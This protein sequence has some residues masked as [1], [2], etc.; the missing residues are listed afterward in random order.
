MKSRE[1]NISGLLLPL[2][3]AAALLIAAAIALAASRSGRGHDMSAAVEALRTMEA[4]DPDQVT[5]IVRGRQKARMEAERDEMRAKLLNGEIDVWSLLQDYVILGDSRP[6]GFYYYG[7]LPGERVLCG[8][9][10]TV[11]L[12]REERLPDIVALNPARAYISYGI[13]DINIGYWDTPE[14]YIAE[15]SS[16][17]DALE[18][19]VPG[20]EIY[21]NSILPVQDWALYKG[22]K[23]PEAPIYSEALRQMCAEKGYTYI[24]NDQICAEHQELYDSDG[25]HFQQ[26]FYDYWAT[27]FVLA[28]YY[29]DEEA[30]P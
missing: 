28:T 16:V 7:I 14:E 8:A 19:A 13:N 10:D 5:E 24:D 18:A 26:A 1:R 27:N 21:I 4:G 17:M 6:A 2:A 29:R 22:E 15:F 23:W 12:I 3:V 30:A 25:I 11:R 9:G 20:I